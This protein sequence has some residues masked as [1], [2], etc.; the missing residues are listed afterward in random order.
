MFVPR[1]QLSLDVIKQY[2]VVRYTPDTPPR[3]VPPCAPKPYPFSCTVLSS[4]QLFRCRASTEV[5]WCL[6]TWADQFVT[7]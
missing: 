3:P 7:C 4:A 2:R 1:E 5:S 6:P